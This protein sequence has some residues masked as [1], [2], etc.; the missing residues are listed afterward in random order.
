MVVDRIQSILSHK[1][2]MHQ[3]ELK[4]LGKFA[5][6]TPLSPNVL[7]LPQTRQIRGINTLLL[8]PDID[9][10]EF[11]FYFDRMSTLLVEAAVASADFEPNR[12]LTPHGKTYQGLKAVGEVRTSLPFPWSD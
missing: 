6:D 1:S 3:I 9:R 2:K 11:I 10:E 12:V 8:G 4:R 5:E 7:F